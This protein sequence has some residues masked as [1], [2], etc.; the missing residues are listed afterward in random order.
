VERKVQKDKGRRVKESSLGT[1]KEMTQKQNR[2][3]DSPE[4]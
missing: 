3:M 1:L 4:R 2:K